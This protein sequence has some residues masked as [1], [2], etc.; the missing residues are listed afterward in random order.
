M[1][2]RENLVL[3]DR[4]T[5]Q[6]VDSNGSPIRISDVLFRITA[7]A[8]RK[9]DYCLQPFATDQEGA[10]TITKRQ[11]ESEVAA[12]QDTGVMDYAH[13][14]TCHPR[15]EI[16]LLTDEEIRRAIEGRNIW[17]KLLMGERDRW[18]S[19]EQLLTV[20]KNANNGR[21]LAL[22]PNLRP[23]WNGLETTHAYLFPVL[24]K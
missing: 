21:L 14:S 8:R 7:F 16:H 19:L 10:A 1:E 23:I 24:A 17:K 18:E 13:I 2:L 4:I 11:L 6:L 20:Y 15:V 9:N 5:I 12:D 22:G 3:P